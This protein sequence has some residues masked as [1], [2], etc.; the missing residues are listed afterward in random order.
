MRADQLAR[1]A[2]VFKELVGVSFARNPGASCGIERP[3][4]ETTTEICGFVKSHIAG[5]FDTVPRVRPVSAPPTETD[6]MPDAFR[7]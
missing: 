2:Q 7:G 5:F 1:P 6:G 4:K 3:K